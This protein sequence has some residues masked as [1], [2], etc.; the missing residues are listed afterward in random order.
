MT[1]TALK[2]LVLALAAAGALA[3]GGCGSSDDS[4]SPDSASTPATAPATAG[5]GVKISMKNIAFDPKAVTVKVG[6]TIT[7]VDDEPIEHNV[8]ATDGA[9]FKS[10]VFGQD[11]TY[12][13]TPKK[14]GEISYECTLHPGMEGKIT[15]VG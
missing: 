13:F 15:V 5:G 9:D 4:S 8:V 1:M 7:W 12:E 3:V 6:Q 10:E 11:G 2:P 14:A